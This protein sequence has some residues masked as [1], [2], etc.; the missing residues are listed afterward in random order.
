MVIS[1][2]SAG[3]VSVKTK[4]ETVT[5]DGTVTIGSF[6]V[7]GPGEYDIADIQC[8]AR[9]LASSFATFLRA[10]ELTVTH[11]A[12][13]DPAVTKLDDAAATHILVADVKSDDQ[14]DTLKPIVKALE[15]SY[16]VLAGP[17]A[18]PEFAKGLGLPLAE[19]DSL[20]LT[21][22]GLPLEGT[23]VLSRA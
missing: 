11:L 13:I 19:G 14:P 16:V 10:E 22:A 9:A 6:L 5:L 8:E 1:Y 15:P 18:T 20:K 4:T 3:N 21:R 17:G 12:Q 2:T 23:Y 7:P